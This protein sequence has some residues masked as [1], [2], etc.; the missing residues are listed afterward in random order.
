[1]EKNPNHI[2]EDKNKA[3]DESEFNVIDNSKLKIQDPKE[4]FLALKNELIFYQDKSNLADLKT[5]IDEEEQILKLNEE[6]SFDDVKE[7]GIDFCMLVDCSESMYPYRI[8]CKKALYYCIKDLE[9]FI[10]RNLEEGDQIPKLRISIVKYSD[11]KDAS[12]PGDVEVL[13]FVDYSSVEKICSMID[14]IDIKSHSIKKRSVFDGLKKVSELKWESGIKIINH[15]AADPQYG[16][17]YTTDLKSVK[18]DYDP[19]PKGVED[20]N[21][22]ELLESINSIEGLKYNLLYLNDRFTRFNAEIS[23]TLVLENSKPSVIE[24]N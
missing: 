15:I 8:Y 3:Y 22:K 5:K 6:I 2:K 4:N 20:I 24:L 7:Q 12:T 21:T 14:S 23:K 11:R 16:D 19:F 18:P 10:Y 1:M 9:N 13:D 17:C